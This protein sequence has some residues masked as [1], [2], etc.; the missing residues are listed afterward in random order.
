MKRIVALVLLGLWAA[1]L[2]LGAHAEPSVKGW[3]TTEGGRGGRI[4]RVTTLNADGPGSFKWAIEQKGPRIVVFEVAGAINL[5]LGTLTIKEPSLTIAGQ[6]AP[7]P[8]ITLTRGGVDIAAHDV[9]IQ[10]IRFRVGSVRPATVQLGIRR[11]FD[12]WRIEHH[13]RP[14]HANLGAR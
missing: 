13:R 7:S 5:N 11:D 4:I 14:L 12:N 3:A 8:G 1:V 9:I 6:T 2:P 10:H